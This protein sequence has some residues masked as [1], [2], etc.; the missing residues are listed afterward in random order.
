LSTGVRLT[1]LDLCMALLVLLMDFLEFALFTQT[2]YLVPA[3]LLC[4]SLRFF[5]TSVLCFSEFNTENAEKIHREHQ[6]LNGERNEPT[7]EGARW[8]FPYN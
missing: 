2:S 3:R 1:S 4:G 8:T 5:V 6:E 7:M